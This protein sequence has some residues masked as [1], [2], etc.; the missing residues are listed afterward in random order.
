MNSI[1]KTLALAFGA[2]G[3]LTGCSTMQTGA[4]WAWNGVKTAAG[5]VE[6]AES[7]TVGAARTT[8]FA[9]KNPVETPTVKTQAQAVYLKSEANGSGFVKASIAAANDLLRTQGPI[10]RQV[11]T[12][13]PLT[14]KGAGLARR[15][16]TALEDA[17]AKDVKLGHYVTDGKLGTK[18]DFPDRRT[19]WDVE[20]VSE[21]YVVTVPDCR[22]ADEKRWTIE[23]Y[24]A[25]GVLG[26]ANRANIAVM[27]SDPRDVLR[28]KALE[29]ADGELVVDV[30]K[31]YQKGDAEELP[32]ID[33]SQDE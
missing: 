6:D 9:G 5:A 19:G 1:V 10:H 26:C 31:K 33:F 18:H 30:Y 7:A 2:A 21:A 23:P 32:E 29:A 3:L 11:L 22:V 15:L 12:V 8:L 13:V 28:P 14:K 4:D 20:L 24:Y 27:T 25:V 16:A 17:G